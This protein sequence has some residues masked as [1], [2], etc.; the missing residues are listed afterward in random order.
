MDDNALITHLDQMELRLRTDLAEIRQD[1]KDVAAT[2]A[3]HGPR[4]DAVEKQTKWI[5]GSAGSAFVTMCGAFVKH[6]LGGGH[7]H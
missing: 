5:W 3:N 6:V 4:L 7:G 2:T 1:V